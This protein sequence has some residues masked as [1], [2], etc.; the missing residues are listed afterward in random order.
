MPM[1]IT[2]TLKNNKQVEHGDFDP[3]TKVLTLASG[4]ELNLTQDEDVKLAKKLLYA[5]VVAAPDMKLTTLNN[6]SKM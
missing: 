3:E 5:Q 4:R 1:Q 6:L 2:Y